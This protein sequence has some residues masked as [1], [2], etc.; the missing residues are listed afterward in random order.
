MY[1]NRHCKLFKQTFKISI[2]RKL[3]TIHIK[4]INVLLVGFVSGGGG[5]DTKNDDDDKT[6]TTTNINLLLLLFRE[7]KPW[8]Y[9]PLH[10]VQKKSC[11]YKGS[12][13]SDI[14]LQN[15]HPLDTVCK[16]NIPIRHTHARARTRT[17]THTHTHTQC[18]ITDTKS[19]SKVKVWNDF[20]YTD[21]HMAWYITFWQVKLTHSPWATDTVDITK[22][23]II[24]S[25]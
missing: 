18:V 7:K 16:Y 23:Y 6:T 8:Y 10:T 11:Q 13:K 21:I 22:H 25:K 2:F 17:H 1:D 20:C 4:K 12:L 14:W 9:K 15:T 3:S 24:N 19:L 5:D